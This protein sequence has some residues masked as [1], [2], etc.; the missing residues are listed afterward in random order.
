MDIYNMHYR[1][2]VMNAKAKISK[3]VTHTPEN[4]NN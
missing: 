4:V 2:E 1:T 3:T